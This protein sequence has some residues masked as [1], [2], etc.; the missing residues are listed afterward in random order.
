MNGELDNPL[1]MSGVGK[2]TDLGGLGMNPEESSLGI[3]NMAG[4]ESSMSI[5]KMG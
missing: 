4:E 1:L 5:G 2:S 3:G